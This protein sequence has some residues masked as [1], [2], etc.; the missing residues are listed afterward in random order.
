MI[1]QHELVHKLNQ[2]L[3][4]HKIKDHTFNGLQFEGKEEVLKIAC[5]VDVSEEVLLS[6]AKNKVDFLITHHGLI[7]GGLNKIAG[8]DKKRL[9][10]LFDHQINLYCSHLPLDLHDELGN[11]AILIDTLGMK[12]T[13]EIFFE[14]GYFAEYE[15]AIPYQEFQAKIASLVSSNITEMNFG[16]T[17]I[18]R[19]AIC[20]GGA[21]LDLR[22]LFEAHEKGA[23]TLF[24]GE[25]NSLLYHYAKELKMN[26]ICA[27]HYA[28]E[29]FGVR[30]V[31]NQLKFLYPHL[32]YQFLDH[33]TGF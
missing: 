24:S 18:K 13:G 15:Q 27:G 22:A 9:Q 28:T 21:A 26:V 30:A 5:A 7:W 16:S 31:M 32:T 25:T 23:D 12:N 8:F 10:I 14:V 17:Q 20:S 1:K 2:W 3:E 29:T 4:P 6:A 11:N 19:V 33:P